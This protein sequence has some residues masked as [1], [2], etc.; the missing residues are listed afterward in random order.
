MQLLEIF[1]YIITTVLFFF[2][3]YM[4]LYNVENAVCLIRRQVPLVPSSGILRNAVIRE[5]N[6]HYPHMKTACDIGSG[7]G[8]LARAI[9][10]KCGMRVTAI[11]NMPRA[12]LVSKIADLTARGNSRTIWRDAFEYIPE[13][14]GFDIAVAYL[15]P[16]VNERLVS[17]GGKVRVLITLD[18]P[19]PGLDAV[20]VIDLP[21]GYTRYGRKKYPHRLFVYEF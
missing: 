9:A 17:I 14:G 4:F 1:I 21:E 7:Y 8:G 19:V 6:A 3:V 10:K 15:G 18:V 16:G 5:I 2:V 13:S 12:A 20:R 11:E